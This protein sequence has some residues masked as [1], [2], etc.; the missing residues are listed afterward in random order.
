MVVVNSAGLH[1][2]AWIAAVVFG[3]LAVLSAAGVLVSATPW[4]LPAALLCLIVAL[5]PA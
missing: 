1:W 4:L 3:V 5:F 2:L